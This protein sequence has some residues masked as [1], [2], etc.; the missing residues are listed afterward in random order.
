VKAWTSKKA[1]SSGAVI[2]RIYR[3]KDGREV[4]AVGQ[5]NDPAATIAWPDL[6]I[7]GDVDCW[8]R[9]GRTGQLE[10]T[11][12]KKTHLQRP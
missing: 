3:L 12:A 2:T 7:L 6:E 1:I 10:V 4:E 9:A 5:S 11:V 8:V